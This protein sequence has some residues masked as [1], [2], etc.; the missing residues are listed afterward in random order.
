MR[1]DDGGS[2]STSSFFFSL[3]VEPFAALSRIT[4]V[5]GV[6]IM[7]V[8]R[9]AP[10][11]CDSSSLRRCASP[12]SWYDVV[13]LDDKDGLIIAPAPRPA[14]LL[15]LTVNEVVVWKQFVVKARTKTN[16]NVVVVVVAAAIS[17]TTKSPII[18]TTILLLLLGTSNGG[19]R[20]FLLFR[21]E[22]PL[23]QPPAQRH[24]PFVAAVLSTALPWP[25]V[26]PM[27]LVTVESDSTNHQM[28][29]V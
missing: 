1:R 29:T 21:G 9:L 18:P 7:V 19:C 22:V 8:P 14:H 27:V 24:C 16:A 12:I 13:V 6:V 11:V 3:L 4:T 20:C 10:V 28:G 15:L 23:R 25:V 26:P 5:V 17:S 2:S